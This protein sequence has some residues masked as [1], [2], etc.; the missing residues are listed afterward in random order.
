MQVLEVLP[1]DTDNIEVT[2][3]V[4]IGTDHAAAVV[5][6]LRQRPLRATRDRRPGRHP[7]RLNRRAGSPGDRGRGRDPVRRLLLDA[8]HDD[9]GVLGGRARQGTPFESTR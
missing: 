8:V 1:G 2:I 5:G 9:L 7:R 6:E 4:E 3:P